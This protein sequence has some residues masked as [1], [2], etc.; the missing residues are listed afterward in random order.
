MNITWWMPG[1]IVRQI[2]RVPP[3]SDHRLL[4]SSR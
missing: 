2:N 3:S 4:L 1:T